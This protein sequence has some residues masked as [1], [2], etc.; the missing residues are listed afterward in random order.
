M[1]YSKEELALIFLTSIE[2]IGPKRISALLAQCEKPQ[3]VIRLDDKV[4]KPILGAP[5]LKKFRDC[6]TKGY[7]DALLSRLDKCGA[8]AVTRLSEGYPP[9][10]EDIFDPPYVLYVKGDLDLIQEKAAAVVGS[11]KCTRYGQVAARTLSTQMA[12]EGVCII[13]GMARGIDSAAHL[14]ALDAGGRTIAVLGCGVD[15][16]YP[17]ENKGLYERICKEGLLVSEYLPGALPLP[18]HFRQRNR[19]IAGL[20][21]ACMLVEGARQS[22]AMIT[23][24]FATDAGREIFAVPGPIDSPL[25]VSP[26]LLI[27]DGAHLACDGMDVVEVMGWGVRAKPRERMKS[28][29]VD[30]SES[31]RRI[32]SPLLGEDLT[33]D[34]LAEMTGIELQELNSLLT[35]LTFRG[36]IKQQP[37]GIYT[38]R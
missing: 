4:L 34:E 29:P 23:V 32:V 8:R 2:G 16:C 14:G 5:C 35:M 12:K 24:D 13:S 25:S 19:I 11:R 22:G 21:H 27:R 33:A 30:L 37:G 15:Q 7:M 38:T 28:V 20:A 18:A 9:L 10:L 26:N 36:I 6:C 3:D 31:E 1:T 17:P